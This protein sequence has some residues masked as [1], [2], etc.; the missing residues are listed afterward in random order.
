MIAMTQSIDKLSLKRV[1]KERACL[2]ILPDSA[3]LQSS[4][5]QV[6]YGLSYVAACE[7]RW[8][9]I[10]VHN[11]DCDAVLVREQRTTPYFLEEE[12]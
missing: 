6:L 1:I 12:P 2:E 11:W 7:I 8:L 3:N 5:V 10:N 9:A 4:P